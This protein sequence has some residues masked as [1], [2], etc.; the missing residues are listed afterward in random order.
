M[1]KIQE[2]KKIAAQIASVRSEISRNLDILKDLEQYKS[3]IESVSEERHISACDGE[4]PFEKPEEMLAL[5]TDL[6]EKNLTLIQHC[7]ESEQAL[8][9]IKQKIISAQ[10]QM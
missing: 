2:A 9:E 6:E 1:E 8:D 3:F 10:K 4:V 5:F 7:Q